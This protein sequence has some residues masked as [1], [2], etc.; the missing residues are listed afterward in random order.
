M[1]T[2]SDEQALDSLPPYTGHAS[3]AGETCT[4]VFGVCKVVASCEGIHPDSRQ[5]ITETC[6]T[7]GGSCT[8]EHYGLCGC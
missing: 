5:M 3:I 7:P 2:S 1:S 8:V 6:C 4:E